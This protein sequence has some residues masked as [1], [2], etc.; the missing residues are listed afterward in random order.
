MYS[1]LTSVEIPG[2][3]HSSMLSCWSPVHGQDHRSPAPDAC[4]PPVVGGFLSA[5]THT[6]L[7]YY[8]I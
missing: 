7:I 1:V 3:G 2:P 4:W 6:Q 5:G 8:F